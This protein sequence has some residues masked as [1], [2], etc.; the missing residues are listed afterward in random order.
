MRV[1]H[2]AILALFCGVTWPTPSFGMSTARITI[3]VV[4][5]DAKPVAD[6]PIKASFE[7]GDRNEGMTDVNG[8]FTID[9]KAR[10]G[11]ASYV[12]MKDGY[13]YGYGTYNLRGGVKDDRF[14]PWNPVVTA[15]VRRVVNPI[16]MYRKSVRT[17]VPV[18]NVLCG[19][20]LMVGD[21]TT[22]N[23]VGQNSDI[24]FRVERTV[25]SKDEYDVTLTVAFTNQS[26][27]LQSVLSIPECP[28][29]QSPRY[30]P[31]DGYK[32]EYGRIEGRKPQKGLFNTDP[33]SERCSAYRIRSALDEKGQ[34]KSA[35]YGIF[36]TGFGIAGYGTEK[37]ALNFT[38]FLN[39]TPN[40]RNLEFD[41][42]R[43][44]ELGEAE[45]PSHP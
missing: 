26:D 5:D 17:V 20:D 45:T 36:A 12:L 10:F 1:L 27:G 22:P 14:Q 8:L 34:I 25:V 6:F 19:Y 39:P 29:F 44:K 28:F 30:A 42:K 31:K 2:V 9:G 7:G 33:L 11:R 24:S 15:V 43:L 37:C 13:Y 32:T 23:G 18:T 38:Y 40:D 35:Y 4:D 16:S 3:K 41:P 21:W